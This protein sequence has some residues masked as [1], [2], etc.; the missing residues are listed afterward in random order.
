MG[1]LRAGSRALP[2]AAAA[3]LAV[4]M[5]L[6]AGLV[7]MATGLNSNGTERAE[8]AG[9]VETIA[10]E[11]AAV[12]NGYFA[13]PESAAQVMA[14][15]LAKGPE[16]EIIV[17]LLGNLTAS[18]SNV[19]GTFVGYPDGSFIDVRRDDEPGS[20]G[21]R[22]KTISVVDGARTVR[23]EIVDPNLGTVDEFFLEE[24]TYDPRE[25]P[26]YLGVEA[27]S[28]H[29][30]EPYLFFTSQ[31]PGIT[32][33]VPVLDE[34]GE[35]AAVVGVDI[36]LTDLEAFLAARKPSENGGAA[37]VNARGELGAGATQLLNHP[38]GLDR[39]Q[40]LLA[41]APGRPG[42]VLAA[43]RITGDTARVVVGTPVGA[44]GTQ[45]L[46][47]DAPDDDFLRDIRSSRRGYAILAATLGIAGILLLGL[48]AGLIG[49]YLGTLGKMARTDPLTGLL[50]RA[51]VHDEMA[52][53][54]ES[55]S[56][57]AVMAI[58]L[59][60]FKAVNDQFGHEGGDRALTR[61]AQQLLKAA[62]SD[63]IIGRLGGDEFCIVLVDNP[64]PDEVLRS[65][66]QKASGLVEAVDYSF[67][68]ALSAGFTVSRP[69]AVSAAISPESAA[70]LFCNA[71]I[72]M[73]EAKANPGTTI[74]QF[75]NAMHMQ[76]HRDDE[77]RASLVNAIDGGEMELHFQ[78]EVDLNTNRVV[79]AAGLLRWN[80]PNYGLVAAADFIADLDRFGLLP[81]LLATI[82]DEVH[83]L[84]S[85]MPSDDLFTIRLNMSA[86]QLLDSSLGDHLDRIRDV[87][88]LQVCLEVTETTMLGATPKLRAVFDRARRLGIEIAID[89]FGIGHSA[90]S[91]VQ[92]LPVDVLKIDRVFMSALD[93]DDQDRS[94]AAVLAHLAWVMKIDAV[95]EGIETDEQRE[96][97][98]AIGC[99]RGQGYLFG[100]AMPVDEFTDRWADQ[101]QLHAA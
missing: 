86:E 48:G 28:T 54:L 80:S 67:D 21:F 8:I 74:V 19:D 85:P 4:A 69:T 84:A 87:A 1:T 17:D 45:L 68:L 77:R 16:A 34:T 94:V 43:E 59:D 49:R 57:V 51:A 83:R 64:D 11:S 47:V 3:A 56:E 91:E 22:V 58:D 52:V 63:A 82:F 92:Q 12:T 26:W 5:M 70:E 42:D 40:Q 71:D 9:V 44:G 46:I 55:G 99:S 38:D 101:R 89:N 88:G 65:L 13:G 75:D 60:D 97:A 62:P 61:V 90:L 30:T 36:R 29:W 79:G 39:I 41:A 37:V 32:Y 15:S 20:S 35:I 66:I 96:A 53:A 10:A 14:G 93:V 18:Q 2:L 81:K 23:V 100:G 78:P 73:Y 24:D 25:R 6:I 95:A 76:W 72:A 31:E 98:L 7:A 50:N 27:T 33:S